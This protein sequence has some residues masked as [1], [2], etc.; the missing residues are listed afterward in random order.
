MKILI[1]SGHFYPEITPRAFRTTEL[2]KEFS[3]LGHEVKVIFPA[4]GYDYS[5]F[6]EEYSINISNYHKPQDTMSGSKNQFIHLIG[7][8]LTYSIEYPNIFIINNVKNILRNECHD[9][10]LLISIAAPHPVHW[11]VAKEYVKG[12]PLAKCWI[13]DCGDPYMLC[14]TLNRP[15]PFFFKKIEKLWCNLCDF[16]T[17]PV[18]D[19]VKGYYPEFSKKIRI[20]PQAFNFEEVIRK[21]YTPNPIPTFA[22]SGSIWPGS[23]DPSSILDY[24]CTIDEDFK[25]YLYTNESE[26]TRKYKEKLRDKLIISPFLPRIEL[27][28]IL[29]G[30]D[31]LINFEFETSIQSPSKMIDYSLTQR[32]ILSVNCANLDIKK[33]DCFLNGDYSQRKIL[34]NLDEYNIFN[35]AQKFLSLAKK[36]FEKKN[37]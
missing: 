21:K 16:I 17:V 12:K 10:D 26:I 28:E 23:K 6:L 27:L 22:Y 9:Y 19:A 7:R 24:L 8:I 18:P 14:G 13:A 25:F 3:R 15:K 20:I 34:S 2:A 30:M 1:I 31:F 37:I 5:S 4:L 11:A 32:P 33:I 36:R 35:V 29:S